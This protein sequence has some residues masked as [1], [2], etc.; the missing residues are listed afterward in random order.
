MQQRLQQ[1][2]FHDVPLV[3]TD[4]YRLLMAMNTTL[5]VN[6]SIYPI[7]LIIFLFECP[8]LKAICL[9]DLILRMGGARLPSPSTLHK[10]LLGLKARPYCPGYTQAGIPTCHKQEEVLKLEHLQG[11]KELHQ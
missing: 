4:L 9:V 6:P 2:E 1:I 11:N 3:H 5:K 8:V 7:V 10:P